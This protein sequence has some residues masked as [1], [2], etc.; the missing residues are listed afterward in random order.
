MC[1]V[2]EKR[3]SGGKVNDPGREGTT[4]G[5]MSPRGRGGR[6]WVTH[7]QQDSN[8]GW[9]LALSGSI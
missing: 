6:A 2:D 9:G 3:A 4:S 1:V 8:L 5:T 7:L